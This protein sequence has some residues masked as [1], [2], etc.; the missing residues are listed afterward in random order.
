M[1]LSASAQVNLICR[2][3]GGILAG[4]T[5]QFRSYV[6]ETNMVL[7]SFIRNYSDK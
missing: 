3:Q 2:K 1:Q 7:K 5:Y 6:K 4:L